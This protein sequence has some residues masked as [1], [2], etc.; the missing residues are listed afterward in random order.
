MLFVKKEK[1]VWPV[2]AVSP[3]WPACRIWSNGSPL[4]P[5]IE[6]RVT[7]FGP[8]KL[9][10][11]SFSDTYVIQNHWTLCSLII[12]AANFLYHQRDHPLAPGMGDYVVS[13]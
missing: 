5:E 6:E 1:N 13:F 4:L 2:Q 12:I 11:L 3:A 10:C 9:K 7:G 8:A